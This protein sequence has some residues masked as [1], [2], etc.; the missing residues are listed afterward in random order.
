MNEMVVFFDFDDP[1][2]YGKDLDI[3]NNARVNKRALYIGDNA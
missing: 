2:I 3:K 1:K